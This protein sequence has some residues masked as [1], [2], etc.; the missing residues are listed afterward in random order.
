M[1][2][3]TPL[4]FDLYGWG[5]V[6]WDWKARSAAECLAGLLAALAQ[7]LALNRSGLLGTWTVA[8]VR[9]VYP[10]GKALTL[11]TLDLCRPWE[12]IADEADRLCGFWFRD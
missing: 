6:L 4:Y 10:T 5:G 3:E 7:Q 1:T 9:L 11:A 12:V 2:S 8:Y